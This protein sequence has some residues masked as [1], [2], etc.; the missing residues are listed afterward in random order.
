MEW[1]GGAILMVLISIQSALGGDQSCPPEGVKNIR[2]GLNLFS[3][4]IDKIARQVN[5]DGNLLVSPLSLSMVVA[6]AWTGARGRTGHQIREAFNFPGPCDKTLP[7][8]GHL[9]KKVKD[10]SRKTLKIINQLVIDEKFPVKKSFRD[11]LLK[12]FSAETIS[13]D[14]SSANASQQINRRIEEFTNNKIVDLI[15]K[16]SLS[17]VAQLLLVNAVHFQNEWKYEFDVSKTKLHAFHTPTGQVEVPMMHMQ[18]R[19]NMAYLDDIAC[20][21]LELPYVG[22]N[23]SMLIVLP[24]HHN[25]LKAVEEKWA[26]NSGILKE[27]EQQ[28]YEVP[29][30]VALPKFQMNGVIE[31]KKVLIALNITHLF[32]S[33]HAD[34]SGISELILYVSDVFHKTFIDVN[35]KGTEVAA[36]T[37]ALF[38]SR[39]LVPLQS[40]VADHPF[41]F[42][43]LDRVSRSVIFSGRLSNPSVK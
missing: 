6:M 11:A 9:I 38:E 10:R 26:A 4:S 8:V 20:Q 24:D 19:F 25:G 16:E 34:L 43:L 41:M 37:V 5:P 12:R 29:V 28:M 39:S 17:E 21:V 31:A 14:F 35:E 13:I 22:S 1:K 18:S 27:L 42:F 40:F 3:H 23:V 7:R 32:D 15:P 30:Q 36:A 2:N 33:E